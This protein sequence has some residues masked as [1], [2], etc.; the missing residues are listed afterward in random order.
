MPLGDAAAFLE[1]AAKLEDEA[2]CRHYLEAL[3]GP[4]AEFVRV[5]EASVQPAET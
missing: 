3:Q 2:R 4:V 5:A 1:A